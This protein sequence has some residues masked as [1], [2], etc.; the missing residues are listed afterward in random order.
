VLSRDEALQILA[1]DRA[2][3][4]REAPQSPQRRR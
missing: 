3:V 1:E 4:Q 2:L